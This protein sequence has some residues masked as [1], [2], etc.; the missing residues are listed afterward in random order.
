MSFQMFSFELKHQDLSNIF[1]CVKLTCTIKESMQKAIT[2][3]SYAMKKH[4]L[5]IDDEKEKYI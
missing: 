3:R 5:W 4:K 1:E 2:R